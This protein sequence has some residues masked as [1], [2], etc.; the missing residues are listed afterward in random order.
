MF[1]GGPSAAGVSVTSRRS[2]QRQREGGRA[3]FGAA[4]PLPPSSSAAQL[5]LPSGLRTAIER[6]AFAPSSHI[7]DED[8]ASVPPTWLTKSR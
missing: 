6:G 3:C 4:A 1:D 5:T 7:A 2:P 8:H